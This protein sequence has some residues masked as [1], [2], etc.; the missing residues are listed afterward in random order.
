MPVQQNDGS[1]VWHGVITDITE[2]KLAEDALRTNEER[3]RT[4]ADFTYDMEFWMDENKTLQYMSPSCKRITGYE[5]DQFLQDPSLL[6][7]IVYSDDRLLFDQHNMEEFD[8]PDSSSLDFR[9][10]TAAGEVRWIGHACQ[11]VTG[12]DGKFRGRRVSH[13]D[14][15]E[16]R[17]VL[18]ELR[19]SEEK[20]RGL[21][22]SLDSVIA[23]V[24]SNGK[25]LYMNDKAAAQLGGETSQFVGKTM[26]ELF[27]EQVA[28]KQMVDIQNVIET[29]LGKVFE[30]LSFV[31]GLP[32]WY[33]TFIQPLHDEAGQ[34]ASVLVNSTDIHAL[35]MMQQELQELNHT[36]EEKVTQR[37]A[38][39]Q[40]LYE[41][42]ATGY[43]SIDA[44]G[45]FVRVNQTELDWLGYTREDMIGHAA[46]DFM[47]VAT[48]G[49]FYE[50]FL[51]LIRRGWVKDVEYEFIR[52][53]G[54]NF[55][56]VSLRRHCNL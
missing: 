23:T 31:N 51:L 37:T 24:D 52:K 3:I 44:D 35:K 55:S 8:L 22:E 33:R 7:R 34:V 45:N 5:R 4:V 50:N 2:R 41:N 11:A 28:K 26:Y 46:I 20:Y 12:A 49:V 19:A 21:L 53:N 13:R 30:N 18:Q 39:V 25:F 14:V 42:A 43:H 40:D 29:D 6:Q 47:T 16:Q 56:S 17:R 10:M 27:P 48:R 32:R 9:I 15:T 1:M 38:E 54:S 36:L